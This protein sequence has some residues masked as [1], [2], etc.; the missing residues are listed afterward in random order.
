MAGANMSGD[1]EDPGRAIPLGTLAALALTGG[2]YIGVAVLLAASQPRNHL[3]GDLFVM[4]SAAR[5]PALVA[6]GVVAATLSS[7]RNNFV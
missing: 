5:W 4:G 3:L 1:L 6:A 2:V 7:A